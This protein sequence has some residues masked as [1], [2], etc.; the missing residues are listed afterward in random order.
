MCP[1]SGP[2]RPACCS[3]TRVQTARC[4]FLA[5]SSSVVSGSLLTISCQAGTSGGQNSPFPLA[6]ARRAE[7]QLSIAS[8]P[9]VSRFFGAGPLTSV[10]NTLKASGAAS[11]NFASGA[12]RLTAKAAGVRTSASASPSAWNTAGMNT[13]Q[14][15]S[16]CSLRCSRRSQAR[17]SA[18]TLFSLVVS[19]WPILLLHSGRHWRNSC[20]A[21]SMTAPIASSKLRLHSSSSSWPVSSLS[22]SSFCSSCGAPATSFSFSFCSSTPRLKESSMNLKSCS[23]SCSTSCELRT[24]VPTLFR[25]SVRPSAES[26][27]VSGSSS[28]CMFAQVLCKKVRRSS[29]ARSGGWPR[30][31]APVRA[32]LI[33]AAQA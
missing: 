10:A 6:S 9:E 4:T 2:R 25:H 24:P 12:A 31:L 14:A 16:E 28:F 18:R 20:G 29:L 32:T 30:S 22:S 19:H 17:N 1:W 21:A 23:A 3:S 27:R 33:N 26:R 15:G 8:L 5:S 7:T 11:P 13:G